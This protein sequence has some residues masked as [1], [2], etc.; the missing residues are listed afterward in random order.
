MI[1]PPCP[2][3]VEVYS[4]GGV[5]SSSPQI[6]T[7]TRF[8]ISKYHSNSRFCRCPQF[9]RLWFPAASGYF[10]VSLVSFFSCHEFSCWALLSL[11]VFLYLSRRTSFLAVHSNHCVNF[12]RTC[13]QT[14]V[15]AN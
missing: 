13:A 6:F 1:S 7:R 11:L 15:K 4:N 10:S 2:G 9:A 8:S 14:P 12:D 3:V 5:F